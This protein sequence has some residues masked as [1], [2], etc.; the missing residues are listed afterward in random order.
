MR[1]RIK[2]RYPSALH[3]P[4]W[5]SRYRSWTQPSTAW[6]SAPTAAHELRV[7]AHSWDGFLDLLL[8]R[9]QPQ[10]VL[11]YSGPDEREG[12]EPGL[13]VERSCVTSTLWSLL[14]DQKGSTCPRL[15]WLSRRYVQSVKGPQHEHIQGVSC[16]RRRILWGSI[17]PNTCSAW[18]IFRK[19]G[20]SFCTS[21]YG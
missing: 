3:Q 18:N 13:V 15:I 7:K 14:P 6:K 5:T 19:P 20:S 8:R 4:Y 2:A 16:S 11:V 9:G 21:S 1:F 10:L 17:L 12:P